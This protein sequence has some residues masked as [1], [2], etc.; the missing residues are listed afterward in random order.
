MARASTPPPRCHPHN[1][2]WRQPG[3]RGDLAGFT[4]PSPAFSATPQ[5]ARLMLAASFLVNG[6]WPSTGAAVRCDCRCGSNVRNH[7]CLP[8]LARPVRRLIYPGS[9]ENQLFPLVQAVAN[10]T[11]APGK[12]DIQNPSSLPVLARQYGCA[13]HFTPATERKSDSYSPH[14]HSFPSQTA[15]SGEP[16]N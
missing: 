2:H 5:F 14:S 11:C 9:G 16:P 4:R 12:S 1:L 7:S 13:A 15:L 6:F 8:A 10:W 3:Q